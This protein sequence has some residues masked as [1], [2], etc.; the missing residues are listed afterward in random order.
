MAKQN[1]SDDDRVG[2]F[3][4]LVTLVVTVVKVGMTINEKRKPS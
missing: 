2:I 1:F 3:A 4:A